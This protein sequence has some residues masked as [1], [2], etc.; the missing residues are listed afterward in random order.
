MAGHGE[1]FQGE[2]T[3]IY[4]R[5]ISFFPSR[6]KIKYLI[7]FSEKFLF[8][9]CFLK[10]LTKISVKKPSNMLFSINIEDNIFNSL[11]TEIFVSPCVH[12]LIIYIY[13]FSY[14]EAALHRKCSVRRG[15]QTFAKYVLLHEMRSAN[16]WSYQ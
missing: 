14:N 7:V 3:S 2:K 1:K 9:K 5:V 12:T 15:T 13:I 11:Y 6:W 10:F 4:K 16:R 8:L